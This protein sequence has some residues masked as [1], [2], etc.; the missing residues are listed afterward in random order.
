MITME[1]GW[2]M[3]EAILIHT[4]L[5]SLPSLLAYT[6]FFFFASLRFLRLMFRW[7]FLVSISFWRRWVGGCSTLTMSYLRRELISRRLRVQRREE[8]RREEEK[9]ERDER[10]VKRSEEEKVE[11]D[12]R[13][14]EVRKEKE[15]RMKRRERS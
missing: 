11:R 2:R 9:V 14:G 7:I 6:H 15:V 1:D 3:D 8:K 5:V 4:R 13:E 10:E 12:E